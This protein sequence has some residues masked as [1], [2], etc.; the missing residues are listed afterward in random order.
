VARRRKAAPRFEQFF[1]MRRF[2]PTLAFT[3]NGRQLLFSSDLSGQFNLWRVK[4]TGGWP[5]Q[6]TTFENQA[7]RQVSVSPDGKTILFTADRE[8]DEFHQ[9]YALPARGGWPEAWTD[10]PQV[11][12]FADQFGWSPD[13]RELAYSANAETPTD[14]EVWVRDV[15]SGETRKAFGGNVFAGPAGWSPDGGKL[16]VVDFRSNSDTALHLV[17]D[18]GTRELLPHEDEI[19]YLPGPWAP[20]GSGF[21]LVTDEGR[22]FQG[23]AFF[24]LGRGAYEWVET[25]EGDV[26]EV[27]LSKDGR[28]LAWTV[29]EDGWGRVRLRDLERGEDLPA[30]Q[31]PDGAGAFWGQSQLTLTRDGTRAAAIWAAPQ[32]PP[33]LYVIDTATGK[34]RKV[35]DNAIGG[36]R[37]RDLSAPELVRVPTWDEREIPAWLYRPKARG[38]VPAV[39]CIHGGPEAQERPWYQ[40]FYQYLVSRGF[41]VLAPNIRGSTGYG[42]TYQKLIHR[43]WGGGDLRDFEHLARWL[44]AQDFVDEKRLGVYGGSYGGFATLSCVTRLPDYWAAAVDV[45]GPSNLVTFSKAVPPTWRRFMDEW[46]GNP[47]TEADFLMERSPITYVDGVRAPLLVMQGANDP[48][49]VKGESDQMVERLRGLGRDVEYVVFEDEGHGFTKRENQLRGFRLAADWFDRHLV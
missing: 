20:D 49:V 11:Q 13:G 28:V 38:R 39:L 42:K 14:Q 10:A 24:D 17:E 43:D 4:V 37:E 40:P 48:R 15:A 5:E 12:H 16:L 46:V 47:E 18:G 31:L 45:V 44:Q 30:A 9:I 29:N 7:V 41:A 35:T 21:W 23:L 25:P 27:A 19:K 8:G 32:R 3:P 36:L 22:E 1:A 26:E 2:Q 34:A 6:L 33:E